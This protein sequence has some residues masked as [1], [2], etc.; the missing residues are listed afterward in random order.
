MAKPPG[1]QAVIFIIDKLVLESQL[2]SVNHETMGY[3]VVEA[4]ESIGDLCLSENGHQWALVTVVKWT[5]WPLEA[6]KLLNADKVFGVDES[7]GDLGLS[8]NGHQ[9]RL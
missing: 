6:H 9:W 8:K 1:L 4:A 2:A 7:I 3:M 5:F